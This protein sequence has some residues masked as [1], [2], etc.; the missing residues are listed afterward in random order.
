M[1]YYKT[2]FTLNDIDLSYSTKCYLSDLNPSTSYTLKIDSASP[3]SITP[4]EA[5]LYRFTLPAGTHDLILSTG[6]GGTPAD[7]TIFKN[8]SGTLK[9]L[10]N[11]KIPQ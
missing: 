10:G 4:T 1:R 3:V 5:G 11:F 8:V 7:G 2:G 6:T 9:I